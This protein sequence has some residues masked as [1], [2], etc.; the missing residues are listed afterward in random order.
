MSSSPGKRRW[1]IYALGGG[2][3]HLTRATGLARA[4]IRSN[5]VLPSGIE[6]CI[7]TNSPFADVMPISSELG[8]GHEVIRIAS[9]PSRDETARRVHEQL[10]QREFDVLVVDTFPRGLGGE[11]KDVLPGLCCRK[12]LIHRDLN[13]DYCL[14]FD[15]ASSLK[16]FDLV[17]VPGESAPFS[18]A[19]QAVVTEPWLIREPKEL[20]SPNEARRKL[21][22]DSQ[23]KPVVVVMGCGTLAEIQQMQLLADE[24]SAQSESAAIRFI[25][26]KNT[27]TAEVG[28]PSKAR[29]VSIWPFL[30]VIR[31]VSVIVGSG[32]YNTVNEATATG[33]HLI[34]IAR[35]RLYDRQEKRLRLTGKPAGFSEVA[36]RLA[37]LLNS[38]ITFDT[39]TPKYTNEVHQRSTPTECT[40]GVH[41]AIDLIASISQDDFRGD[42]S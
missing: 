4:A 14:A 42:I 30:E 19:S 16:E 26:P 31:A 24:L 3:G 2:A 32:G 28:P 34:G 25:A 36:D 22:V 38:G 12:V 29:T 13:P 20:L 1:L 37:T 23:T 18:S 27:A 6:I 15:L 11:L 35:K 33:T 21:A 7:L 39:G 17:L 10:T 8:V 5:A 41:Q 40:N 9:D